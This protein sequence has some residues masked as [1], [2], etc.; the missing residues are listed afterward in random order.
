MPAITS[1]G[2]QSATGHGTLG[3]S[4]GVGISETI[5]I[6]PGTAFLH[7]SREFTFEDA[8]GTAYTVKLTL[9]RTDSPPVD[10]AFIHLKI[11]MPD[12]V[13]PTVQIYD[14]TTGGPLLQTIVGVADENR[15]FLGD[16]RYAD[17]VWTKW[18]GRYVI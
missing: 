3:T 15:T 6:L 12:S 4:S 11:N 9:D 2:I 1:F 18:D 8:L 10:G 5:D 7:W 16:Y 13:D 17:N 14:D